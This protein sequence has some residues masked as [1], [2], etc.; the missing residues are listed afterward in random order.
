MCKLC[1]LFVQCLKFTGAIQAPLY[2][3]T[4]CF[5]QQIICILL[6]NCSNFE[7][8]VLQGFLIKIKNFKKNLLAY[9]VIYANL[10]IT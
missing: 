6:N 8:L 10:K 1:N 5:K 7:Q 3:K 4:S 9:I 2:L